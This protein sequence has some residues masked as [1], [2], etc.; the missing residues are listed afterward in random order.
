MAKRMKLAGIFDKMLFRDELSGSSVFSIRPV[1]PV[2]KELANQ[3]GNITVTAKIPVYKKGLPLAVIGELTFNEK[4]QSNTIAADKVFEHSDTEEALIAYLTSEQIGMTLAKAKTFFSAFG[5]DIFDVANNKAEELLSSKVLTK[6]ESRK[7]IA[8]STE[9]TKARETVE[10]LMPLGMPFHRAEKV[11]REMAADETIAAEFKKNPYVAGAKLDI[12]LNACDKLYKRYHKHA[13]PEFPSRINFAATKVMNIEKSAHCFVEKWDFIEK[14]QDRLI[15]DEFPKKLSNFVVSSALRPSSFTNFKLV[16][17][18]RRNYYYTPYAVAEENIPAQVHRLISNREPFGRGIDERALRHSQL[19]DQQQKAVLMCTEM[20]G[21]V[22]IL[23]GGPGTGKTTTLKRIIDEWKVLTGD[24]DGERIVL[25]AP[26]GRASQRMAEATGHVA[27]TIHRMIGYNPYQDSDIVHN[28][29]NPI[30]ADFVII[31]ECSM[32]DIDLFY[33]LLSAIPTGATLLLVGDIYQLESV[34]AGCVLRDMCKHAHVPVVHLTKTYR[35][36]GD[37][38]IIPNARKINEGR[39]DL[40]LTAQFEHDCFLTEEE[41]FDKA[42]EI[43]KERFDIKRPMDFQILVP[44]H[45]GLCGTDNLNVEIQKTLGLS[46]RRLVYGRTSFYRGDKVL[47]TQNNYDIHPINSDDNT[48]YFNGDIGIIKEVRESS[49]V[50]EIGE[51]L[52]EIT[53]D[54]LDSVELAYAMTIHKSQGSEFPVVMVVLP[55]EPRIM[56][57]RNL[58]YTA[59]TRAKDTV[60]IVSQGSA[61]TQSVKT[62]KSSTRR[63]N[64]GP[65]LEKELA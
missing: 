6:E 64:L 5:A 57:V 18:N 52:F 33:K 55:E 1:H 61:L 3:Y 39:T 50:V 7:I 45:K 24:A 31:D 10:F 41:T 63:T 4:Y 46:G 16:V 21:G 53:R 62:S 59:V 28:T 13:Y 25:A 23:T 36:S 44:S 43:A 51:Y 11:A 38:V 19:G 2:G 60:I 47:F 14:I 15:T 29:E 34:G 49:M 9:I 48:G 12:S 22:Y 65:K 42:L 26:T 37:N 32:L 56:L 27:T 17:E 35:Q 40:E 20:R 30:D 58:F 8:V 54:L